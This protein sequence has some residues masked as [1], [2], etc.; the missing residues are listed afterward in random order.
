MKPANQIVWALVI[1]PP[2]LLVQG[3]LFLG[4]AALALL[5]FM[6]FRSQSFK[7]CKDSEPSFVMVITAYNIIGV[8]LFLFV[9][10]L[11]GYKFLGMMGLVF[12]ALFMFPMVLRLDKVIKQINSENE[13]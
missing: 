6:N 11:P 1:L 4:L 5:V 3:S 9:N 8:L 10:F 7:I 2:L 13:S 12:V